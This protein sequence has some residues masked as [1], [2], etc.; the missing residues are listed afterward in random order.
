MPVPPVSHSRFDSFRPDVGSRQKTAVV[1]AT[2]SDS[3]TW[4]LVVLQC[5]LEEAGYF[6]RNLGACCPVEELLRACRTTRPDLVVVSTVNGYGRIDGA[7]LI[8]ALRGVPELSRIP[9]VIGGML[10]TGRSSERRAA[11]ELAELG[12]SGV[13]A[14]ESALAEFRA[15]LARVEPRPMADAHAG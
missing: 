4:G 2:P 7:E 9:V 14:G 6:V 11:A 10:T 13:F 12:Y 3:H 5:L 8:S 15:F 1:T